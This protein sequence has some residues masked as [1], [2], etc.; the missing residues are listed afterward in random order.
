MCDLVGK[1][2]N[3]HYLPRFACP[4]S[5]S[6]FQILPPAKCLSLLFNIATSLEKRGIRSVSGA[7]DKSALLLTAFLMQINLFA[8]I[9]KLRIRRGPQDKL[10]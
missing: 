8:A 9:L 4:H 2:A 1:A 6:M 3:N 7:M 5:Q 10:V